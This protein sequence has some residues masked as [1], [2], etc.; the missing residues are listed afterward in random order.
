MGDLI[1]HFGI[2]WRLLAAQAVNFF[3]LLFILKRYAFGPVIAALKKRKEEAEKGI[4]LS[5]EAEKRM[6]E[7]GK[8][9][10][11]ALLRAREEAL[12]LISKAELEAKKKKEQVRQEALKQSEHII[13][14]AKRAA[15]EEKA[16][17]NEEVYKNA[18]DFLKLSLA[19]VLGKMSPSERD[20][21]LIREALEELRGLQ[22]K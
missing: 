20:E 4:Q 14:E 1:H 7:V 18:S 12:A 15:S 9:R 19:R 13:E 8:E 6:A 21:Q 22:N 3:I 11:V 16:K 2:N 5:R 10:E 17:M